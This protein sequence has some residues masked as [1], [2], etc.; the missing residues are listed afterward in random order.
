MSD[1]VSQK[2]IT[3]F[4]RAPKRSRPDEDEITDNRPS[5]LS[6]PIHIRDSDSDN[7]SLE[8]KKNPPIS[9]DDNEDEVLDISS[10]GIEILSIEIGGS[11]LHS[12]TSTTEKSKGRIFL[13]KNEYSQLFK[14]LEYDPLTGTARCSYSVCKMYGILF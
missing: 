2:S 6:I 3:A 12:S 5:K 10:D 13:W 11:N 4:L 9:I 7:D 8:S 1:T 14:W